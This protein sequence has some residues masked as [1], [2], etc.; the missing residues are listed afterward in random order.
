MSPDFFVTYL[1]ER[2]IF[3]RWLDVNFPLKEF[4]CSLC[5]LSRVVVGIGGDAER[6]YNW[7]PA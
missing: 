2:S 7:Q 1:P 5:Y 3:L 4:N 6:A